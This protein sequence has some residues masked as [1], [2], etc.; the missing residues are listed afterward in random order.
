MYVCMYVCNYVCKYA[1]IE[2]VCEL[3]Y[4]NVVFA[5]MRIIESDSR[6][7]NAA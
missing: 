7:V 6:R 5:G 1:C 3:V 4:V 2:R